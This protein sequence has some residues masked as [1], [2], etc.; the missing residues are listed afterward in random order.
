MVDEGHLKR[1]V[2]VPPSDDELEKLIIDVEKE[3]YTIRTPAETKWLI[4]SA[5]LDGFSYLTENWDTP[6]VYTNPYEPKGKIRVRI[7]ETLT[8]FR[9]EKGRLISILRVPTS[10]P[11]VT[12]DP[13]I[14]RRNRFATGAL[15]YLYHSTD[16]QDVYDTWLT[17]ILVEGTAG[18][19]PYWDDQ[20][21]TR[22]GEPGSVAFRTIPAW[23]LFPFPANAID[24]QS[25]QGIIW[26][27]VVSQEWVK[28]NIPEAENESETSVT[29]PYHVYRGLRSS[30]TSDT[31][32]GH[33][34][35]WIF[36]KP[37]RRFP[38]GEVIIMVGDT[39]YR[40]QGEL[41]FWLGRQRVLPISIA[42]FTKK[43][44][45]W[46]GEGFVYPIA[47][48]NRETNRMMS[49]LVRRAILKA[50]PGYLMSPL[51]IVNTEDFK[52]QIGGL[53]QYKSN[54]FSPDSKP[55]WLTTPPSTADTDTLV[56]RLHQFTED[57]ASQHGPTSGTS[58]GRVESHAAIQSLIR[59][60][61]VP[62]EGA[63]RSID[64]ALKRAFGIALEI[65]RARWQTKRKAAVSGPLG[66]PNYTINFD[67]A[68]LPDMG[69]I[70]VMTSM[71][72]PIDKP[73]MMQ[74]LGSLASTPSVDGKPLI[75]PEEY[76][77]GILAMG[78]QIPGVELMSQ[79]E[80]QAWN[81]NY[82]M[83]G[84]G[85]TPGE[86]QDPDGSLEG[87][88]AHL[89]T[90]KKFSGSPEVQNASPQV[91]AT[92]SRHITLTAS[93]LQGSPVPPDFDNQVA[94][95]LG[96]EYA[97][98]ITAQFAGALDETVQSPVD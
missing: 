69:D 41:P 34:V 35:R 5:V 77:K 95:D 24:D 32:T 91:R 37:S 72:F 70:K 28:Q 43:N 29:T 93:M 49:L 6:R 42:R 60:D 90:H 54:P 68:D 26:S 83:Y 98:E 44:M 36:F 63:I 47:Q 82:T 30:N 40:R 20:M 22:D 85:K 71:D 64:S 13:D 97:D 17:D 1:P 86:V 94:G 52:N 8:R 73:A 7:P 4:A 39:I 78:I 11:V 23:E 9:R 38:K 45:T 27:R 57:A 74:F 33:K 18:I 50:H 15:A 14:W 58:V 21:Q 88:E 12:G 53:I 89:R 59:Q 87:L 75:S 2:G 65:G 25:L 31:L 56:N 62:M 10:A 67:P 76:R 51:G 46:W 16:F 48:L 66:Y 81:E 79:D 92:F 3:A 55:Y 61:M 19:M 84:D 96:D 80:E